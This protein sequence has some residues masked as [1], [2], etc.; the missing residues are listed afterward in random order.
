MTAIQFETLISKQISVLENLTMRFATNREDAND[1]LQDTLFKALK[2]RDKFK[3]NTNVKAWLYTIMRNTYINGYN[4][5]VKSKISHDTTEEQYFLNNATQKETSPT[6]SLSGY[7]EVSELV[8]K[9][10]DTYKVPFK[11]MFHGYKYKEIA[12]KLELPIGTIKSRIFFARQ[13]LSEQLSDY[14]S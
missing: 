8:E 13:K 7:K 5:A 2:N 9:L 4:R 1:L 3:P 14:V 12:D 11:M 6:E 10:E